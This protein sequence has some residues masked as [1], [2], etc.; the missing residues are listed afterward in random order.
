MTQPDG[1]FIIY[2]PKHRVPGVYNLHPLGI[3]QTRPYVTCDWG[4]R[5]LANDEQQLKVQYLFLVDEPGTDPDSGKKYNIA[6]KSVFI[7]LDP[8]PGLEAQAL[9]KH[10]AREKHRKEIARQ[11]DE[12][13]DAFL[14]KTEAGLLDD[15][16]MRKKLTAS[17]NEYKTGRLKYLARKNNAWVAPTLPRAIQDFKRYLHPLVSNDLHRCYSDMEGRED[18]TRLIQKIALLQCVYSGVDND[19]LTKPNGGSWKDEDEVWA[20]WTGF[21]G[22]AEEARRIGRTLETVFRPV[23]AEIKGAAAA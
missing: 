1:Y 2:Q 9:A 16:A 8:E 3:F 21:A 18:E 15:A 10:V 12:W 13:R 17:I 11:V 7:D 14:P 6:L 19:P 4:I 23:I 5:I 20:C 22:S